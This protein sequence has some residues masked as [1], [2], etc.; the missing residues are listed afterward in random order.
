MSQEHL[1]KRTDSLQDEPGDEIELQDF[2]QELQEGGEDSGTDV[3]IYSRHPEED[4][5]KLII[6]DEI[7]DKG[8]VKEYEVALKYVGFGLFH[9]LLLLINGMALSSDAVEVLSISFILP[10]LKQ[11]E[12]FITDWQNGLLSSIIFMGMLFGS[13]IWGSLA[14]ISGRRFTLLI[15]FTINGVMGFLSA[16][17][18]NFVVFLFFRFFS[19]IG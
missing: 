3:E 1:R 18:P 5:R 7:D 12:W 15:S 16:F 14:D 13:Y 10:I 17:S 11:D 8:I 4:Q 9:I 2:S 6:I 19:G